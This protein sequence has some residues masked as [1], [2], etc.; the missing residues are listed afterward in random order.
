MTIAFVFPLNAPTQLIIVED[1]LAVPLIKLHVHRLA[2]TQQRIRPVILIERLEDD[3]LIP[4]IHHRQHRRKHRLR[5]PHATV[6]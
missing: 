2:L 3:N 4:R 5:P 1:E 6:M